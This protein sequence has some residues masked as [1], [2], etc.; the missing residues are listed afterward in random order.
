MSE[1]NKKSYEK[2][3]YRSFVM[4]I[5]FGINMLV[6]ICIMSALGIF[7]DKKFGTSFIMVILFFVG[8][9]AGAQNIYRMAKNIFDGQDGQE[10][11]NMTA[12]TGRKE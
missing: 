10:D 11:K 3:V 7:L 6:P 4:I 9:I 1:K 8:A 2:S 5:Q 12:D